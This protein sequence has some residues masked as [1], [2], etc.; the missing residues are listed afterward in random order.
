MS[1]GLLLTCCF[2]CLGLSK[3]RSGGSE[4]VMDTWAEEGLQKRLPRDE[5]FVSPG[6]LNKAQSRIR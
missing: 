3:H 4:L 2:S 5:N 6:A 1:A